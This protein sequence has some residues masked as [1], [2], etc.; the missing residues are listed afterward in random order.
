MEFSGRLTAFPPGELLQWAVNDRRTGTLVVRRSTREKRLAFRE[1]RIVACLSDDPGEFYGQHLLLSGVVS[2]DELIRALLH[3]AQ[4]GRRLGAVLADLEILSTDAI[5]ATLREH[6]Q[7]LAL[8]LFLWEKGVFYF[9]SAVP[10]SE[11][12]LP[13]PIDPVGLGLEGARWMDEYRRIRRVFVHDDVVLTAQRRPRQTPLSVRQRW[14]LDKAN[15]ERSLGE[16]HRAIGGSYFRFLAAAYELCIHELLD[17][18][19]IRDEP[20]SGTREVSL[21]GVVLEQARAEAGGEENREPRRGMPLTVLK[22]LV[23]V[24]FGESLPD[25]AADSFYARCDGTARL[26]EILSASDQE[27]ELDLLF[28]ALRRGALGLLPAPIHELEKGA[29]AAAGSDR[30]WWQRLV[31][32]ASSRSH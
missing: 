9:E 19:E 26:G 18:E 22:R 24:W 29:G 4:A 30:G 20:S 13:R 3:S 5:Q 16:L 14:I 25:T 23:P 12:L 15:G 31:A 27:R 32:A 2:E 28:V 11:E 21:L 10:P 7:D 17:I 8:D 1:G 6:V